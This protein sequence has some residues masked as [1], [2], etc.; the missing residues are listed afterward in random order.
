MTKTISPPTNCPSCNSI[1][2]WTNDQL[3][4]KNDNCPAKSSK[5]VEHFAK[6]LKIKGLGPKTV[7]KLS[8]DSI[9][10]I[11]DIDFSYIEKRLGSSKLAEKL[12]NEIEKSKDTGLQTLLPAFSIPLF[13][14]SAAE[15]LCSKIQ[16]LSEIDHNKCKEAGLGQKVTD[17]LIEWLVMTFNGYADLPF[18]WKTENYRWVA[19]E[20]LELVKGIVCISG[21]LSSY[22]TKALAKEMLLQN[23]YIVKDNLTK[24]VTILVNESGIE[25]AKTKKAQQNNITIINNINDLI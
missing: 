2:E 1:L 10:K 8:L 3:F 21:K 5:L 4:C 14:R 18:S 9:N 13:G 23:G 15:K 24:D 22:K 17:N 7:E 16:F 19:E 12:V 25:S 6:T 11:Y 20:D